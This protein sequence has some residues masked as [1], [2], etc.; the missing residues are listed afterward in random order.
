MSEETKM[1]DI[2]IVDFTSAKPKKKKKKTKAKT[3]TYYYL[4]NV[5]YRESR[6]RE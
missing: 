2:Q 1:D 6:R 3:G 5:I 4:I